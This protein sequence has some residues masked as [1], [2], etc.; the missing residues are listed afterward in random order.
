MSATIVREQPANGAA[1]VPQPQTAVAAPK[2]ADPGPLGLAAFAI[3]TFLLSMVN[4]GFVDKGVEPVVFGMALFMGGFAQLLAGMWEYRTG[5]T[6]G[7]TAFTAYGAFWL[8]FW[9]L[10]QFYAGKIPEAQLGH[11][12][13]LYLLAWGGFTAY[14][15]IASF[16]TSRAV[17]IVFLLLLATFVVLGIG[18]SGAHAD[19]VK[20]GGVLGLATA[21]AAAYTSAAGVTNATFGRTVLPTRPL[22]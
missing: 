11:A 4:A 1:H 12:V 19:V 15:A 21:A 18:N 13:G 14:M 20:L 9:A 16:R 17:N 8:S 22:S 7:A 2:I 6:F 3:T 5:N 10:V